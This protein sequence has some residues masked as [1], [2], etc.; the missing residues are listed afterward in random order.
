MKP[1]QRDR[2]TH[3]VKIYKNPTQ[4]AQS[5]RRTGL[6]VALAALLSSC[7]SSRILDALVPTDTYRALT[8]QAYGA[9]ARQRLDVYV[10]LTGPGP[11]PIVVFFYGG[12][13]TNGNR[14]DYRFVGEA[15]ASR[16]ILAVLADYRL[17]PQVRYPVFLQDCAQAVRWAFDRG[18]ALGGDPARLYAM[19]HSAGAYNAA[20]LALDP[21]WLA[22]VNLAPKQLAGWI[23]IAGPYDFLPIKVPEVQLAFQWP[24]TPADSQPLFFAGSRAP[25]SLLIAA[26]KDVLVDPVRNTKAMAAKL[27]ASGTA[28]QLELL[29]GVSHV[30]VIAAMAKPLRRLAPVFER[31]VGFVGA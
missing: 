17:S 2:R 10:P 3:V 20:M 18:T 25:R 24:G 7:S 22:A 8:D 11:W 30:T 23:G 9:D 31:V 14:A 15:L 28:V 29:E 21:R 16:G 1:D 4:G 27:Q 19:G 5:G 6:F 12:S 26:A 13:W